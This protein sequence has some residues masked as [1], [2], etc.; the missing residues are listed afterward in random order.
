M[1]DCIE[2]TNWAELCLYASKLNNGVRCVLLPDLTNGLHH[3]A[4]V[5]EFD[6]KIRWLARIQ[7]AKPTERTARKLQSEIDTMVLVRERTQ[8]PVPKVFGYEIDDKHGIGVAFMLTDFLPGNVAIDLNGGYAVHQ[9]Q[10]PRGHC[11]GF[12]HSV[13]QIQ[14]SPLGSVAS[15][16]P[17]LPR[18]AINMSAGTNCIP[19]LP[20]DRDD[21]QEQ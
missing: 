14:V 6:D 19:A 1:H 9:G 7:M 5:L 12:Y 13:A 17:P 20:K 3:V 21:Y 18:I 10:I 15:T 8:I 2:R 16:S 4:R 11:Q